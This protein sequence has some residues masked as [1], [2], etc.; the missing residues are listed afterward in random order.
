ML[1]RNLLGPFFRAP[2]PFKRLKHIQ[3][4]HWILW[5]KKLGEKEEIFLI[6]LLNQSRLKTWD[7]CHV[8]DFR[9]LIRTQ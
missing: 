5:I 3:M 6:T 1:K 8:L 7:T 4:R 9:T 2:M